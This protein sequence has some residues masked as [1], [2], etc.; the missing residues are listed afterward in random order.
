VRFISPESSTDEEFLAA[1]GL[2]LGGLSIVLQARFNSSLHAAALN[3][4]EKRERR[5]RSGALKDG[6]DIE[7]S[8]A[9][10]VS[11]S[12]LTYEESEQNNLLSAPLP[13]L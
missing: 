10:G 3:N 6:L 9:F 7:R 2:A 5:Q 8:R 11:R 4:I 13:E 1:A 12:R